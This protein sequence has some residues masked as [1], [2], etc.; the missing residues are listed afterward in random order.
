MKAIEHSAYKYIYTNDTCV[1]DNFIYYFLNISWD[2]EVFFLA[3]SFF[4]D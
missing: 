4:I 1:D 2:R 3:A